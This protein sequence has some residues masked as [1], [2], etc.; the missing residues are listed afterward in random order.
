MHSANQD[1]EQQLAAERLQV[2]ATRLSR[3]AHEQVQKRSSL[4]TRWLDDYR[5]YHG[6]YDPETA[7]RLARAEGSEVYVNITRNKTNAAEA[8]LQDMLF[9]T[10]DRNWGIQPTPVPELDR[11][12]PGQMAT[13]PEGQPVDM[14]KIA[15]DVMREA[16][17]KADGMQSEI[18]D[19][20]KES[21]FQIKARDSIH[22]A[23]LMGTGVLKGPVIVGRMHKRWD[24]GEDGTSVLTIEEALEPS[25]ERVDPWDFYPD[26]SARTV[27]ECEFIFERRMMSKRQLREFARLPGTLV[28]QIRAVVKGGKDNTAIAKDH[29]NDIRAITGVD[30]IS[31]DTKYEVWEYHGPISK[32]ELMDA[33]DE[34]G[35]TLEDAEIDELDDE[36]E[37]VVFFS[38]NHVL[39]VVLNPMDTDD[40]PYSVFNWEKD[41]SCI[42]GFGIPY[43]MR[44]PQRVINAA[45]RMMLDNA[46]ASVSDIIV[47]NRE[48]IVPADGSWSSQPGKKKLYFLTEKGRNVHDVFGSFTIPNHQAELAAIFQMARQLADEETNLPLI[49]QGEQ[50]QHVTKTSSGMAMLMNSANIVLRR[51]VKNWDDDITRPTIT[52]FYD[53]NMQYSSKA[54]IKG[55]YSIDARGSGALLV[56]EKQQESL[57]VYANISAS[58]PEFAIRRDWAG[59]DREI[60]KALEVPYQNITLSDG[61]VESK[62][63]QMAEQQSDPE[64]QI[65]MAEL[66]LKQQELQMKAQQ[67]QAD[68]QLRQQQQ[69]WD[70]QY[71]AAQ[72]QSDQE[73]ARQKMALDQGMTQAELEAK[74]GLESQKIELKMQ[75]TAAKI[76]TERD[77]AAAQLT[78]Q[79]NERMSRQQNMANGYD[80]WG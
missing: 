9:P 7:S 67:Q 30:S 74:L 1:D 55:D 80:S 11:I 75:E 3:K 17:K 5:Q 38:G 47:A 54:E 34:S 12:E 10:D 58:N 26:M 13:G 20:L 45:W 51:A 33:M 27:D 28:D 65:K 71:K 25:I 63:K 19:Q 60:A 43:L 72:L 56:R 22:D 57:M 40:R 21:R 14:G 77:K 37:A 68:F 44:S 70:Q 59:M 49:A 41:E 29:T 73:I 15:D 31:S 76:Q 79:Q 46:G 64:Q 52:R 32:S 24:T 61:D 78:D 69:Q 8:R 53:W 62:R 66:Q 42:F 48:A 50:S 39:K 35:E 2:F 23:A 4:E 36:V 18:D 16:K 6:E